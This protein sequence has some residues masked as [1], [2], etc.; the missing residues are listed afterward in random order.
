MAVGGPLQHQNHAGRRR[1]TRRTSQTE[2]VLIV[3]AKRQ[4]GQEGV[5]RCQKAVYRCMIG[6]WTGKDS[7][8]NFQANMSRLYEEIAML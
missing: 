6:I 7:R 3:L 2:A 4:P 1:I 5:D 8:D